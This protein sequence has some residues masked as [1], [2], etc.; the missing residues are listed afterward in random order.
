MLHLLGL[1]NRPKMVI[2]EFG[3]EEDNTMALEVGYN[4]IHHGHVTAGL[5]RLQACKNA[6]C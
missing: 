4:R 5:R 6:G 3:N 1:G 2:A